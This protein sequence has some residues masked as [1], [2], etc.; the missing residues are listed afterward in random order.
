MSAYCGIEAGL[1]GRMR[2][3]VTGGTGQV[4][5]AL[6]RLAPPGSTVVALGS[7]SCDVTD[8]GSVRRAVETHRPELIVH[9]AAM[10]DVDGC[11]R[12]P[13]RA[14]TVNALGTQH[15]A[16]AAQESGARLVYLSTNYVF[17]GEAHEPYHEFA[18]PNPINV[19]GLTK[20][21][22]EDIVRA[23]CPRHYI[24]RTAMVYDEQGRNFVNTI[25]QLARGR[26]TLQVV[27]DQFGNPTSAADLAGALW[28]L[29]ETT[30]YGTYHLVN[31]G[32]A[33]WFEWASEVIRLARL[34]TRVEPIP[35]SAYQRAARPP[36][37]GVLTSLAAPALGITLPDWRDALRRNLA[38]RASM[39]GCD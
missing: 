35:A 23:I 4:G 30:A 14:W 8:P 38:Q 25:L 16:A 5:R 9:C 11:E 29:V 21:A 28:Q 36:R 7:Q 17:D 27:A 33:S 31:A 37:N 26:P 12:D 19:Y 34:P 6:T 3:L 2:V 15:V 1:D 39:L 20:L 32:Q 10:T 24:V 13:H 22:G 18:R